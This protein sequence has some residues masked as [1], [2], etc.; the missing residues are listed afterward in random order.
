MSSKPGIDLIRSTAVRKRLKIGRHLRVDLRQ[1]GSEG[2]D[3]FEMKAQQEAMVVR[4]A[5]T[6]RLAQVLR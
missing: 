1:G 4:H 6:K 2:V 3:L 5:A